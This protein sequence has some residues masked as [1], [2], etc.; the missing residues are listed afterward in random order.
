MDAESVI[1]AARHRRYNNTVEDVQRQITAGIQHS[2]QRNE[3]K[4][5][6][7]Q[8]ADEVVAAIEEGIRAAKSFETRQLCAEAIEDVQT[9]QRQIVI[10]LSQME[11]DQRPEQQTEPLANST[12][13]EAIAASGNM[14]EPKVPSFN[15]TQTNWPTFRD[16]FT[17]E[18]HNRYVDDVTKL[19]YLKEYCRGEAGR[20]IGQWPITA[21]NYQLAWKALCA[22]YN[23]ER[24]IKQQAAQVLT[25]LPVIETETREGL[26]RLIDQTDGALRQLESAGCPTNQWD[27]L[28]ISKWTQCLPDK[29]YIKWRRSCGTRTDAT[30]QELR[31]FVETEARTCDE[32]ERR[33]QANT[34][35]GKRYDR[36]DRRGREKAEGQSYRRGS[37]RHTSGNNN[38]RKQHERGPKEEIRKRHYDERENRVE[39]EH[40]REAGGKGYKPSRQSN[41]SDRDN[42]RRYDHK[43]KFDEEPPMAAKRPRMEQ[44]RRE[45]KCYVCKGTHKIWHCQTFRKLNVQERQQLVAKNDACGRCLNMHNHGACKSEYACRICKGAH[46]TL[47][48]EAKVTS[49]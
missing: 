18:V 6:I 45:P 30:Y 35:S 43:P 2:R 29:T 11:D 48:C 49:Q 5:L 27:E 44:E 41:Y 14:R 7:N 19:I 10:Q 33:Q 36:A 15:G 22:R 3:L 38:R 20:A 31:D 12:V 37:D 28:I 13:R 9:T 46:S 8:A 1:L 24:A 39:G 25:T 32:I 17:S 16:I 23:D 47:L 40:K 21:A 42:G 34:R 26:R 4:T